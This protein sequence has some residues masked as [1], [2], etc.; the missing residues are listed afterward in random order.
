[1]QYSINIQGIHCTGC[2]NLIKMSLEEVGL[3][4]VQVNQENNFAEFKSSKSEDEI[5]QLLDKAFKEDL[6][7][8]QYSNLNIKN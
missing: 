5:N 1:M 6:Q 7:S 4:E 3:E 8:Y 2:V